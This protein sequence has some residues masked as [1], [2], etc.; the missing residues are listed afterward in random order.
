MRTATIVAAAAVLAAT[1]RSGWPESGAGLCVQCHESEVALGASTGGHAAGLDCVSCHQDRRPGRIGAGHRSIP[2][3]ATHHGEARHPLRGDAAR[4]PN[5]S[6]LACH[7]VHGSVNLALIRHDLRVRRRLVDVFFTSEA[8][9]AAGGFTDPERPGKGLCEACHRKTRFYRA[10]G[11]GEPHFTDSCTLCHSH[12]ASFE[13]AANDSNCALCH[14]DEAQRFAKPSEHAAAFACSGCHPEAAAEP[15]PGHRRKPECAECHTNVT[16]APPGNPP[17]PCTQC[18][19]PHGTANTHLVL[20]VLRTPQGADRP[21]RFDNLFGRVDG[22][23]TSASMPGTGICEVCH[24]TTR[25]YRADGTGE[26][27]FTF[28]CLPCHLHSTGF[29]AE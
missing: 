13:F 19:D 1:G 9:H 11:Q 14:A 22:S 16:H 23:F 6:C 7:D 26:E 27:H 18:H 15:G 4:R 17:F 3:C 12:E 10:D 5:R 25:F 2:R 29:I 20:D 28:S 8:G 24:T 21:I